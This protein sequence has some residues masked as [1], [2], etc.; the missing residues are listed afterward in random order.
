[1]F[2]EGKLSVVTAAITIEVD[3]KS[4]GTKTLNKLV[5]YKTGLLLKTVYAY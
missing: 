4:S 2:N 5:D 3:E 1:M